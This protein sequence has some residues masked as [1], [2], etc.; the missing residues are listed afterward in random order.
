MYKQS[1]AFKGLAVLLV[2]L[3][4][5]IVMGTAGL[6][7]INIQLSHQFQI[8]LSLLAA[9]GLYAVPL[10]LFYSGCFVRYALENRDLRTSYKIIFS[11]ILIVLWPYIIW[12]IVFYLV[13][14]I[15]GGTTFSLL[16]YLKNLLVGYPFNFVPILIFFYLL[17]PLLLKAKE[18]FIVGLLV[19]FLLYQVFLILLN[20]PDLAGSL[21]E[22]LHIFA[23]PVVR[24]PLRTWALYFPLGI[25]IKFLLSNSAVVKQY[26]KILFIVLTLLILAV[27]LVS[28]LGFYSSPWIKY[29]LP[30]PFVLLSIFWQREKIPFFKFFERLGKRSYGI[31]LINLI[32]LDILVLILISVLKTIPGFPLF[33]FV[34]L[35]AITVSLPI[36]MMERFEKLVSKRIYRLIFG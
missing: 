35:F 12:S 19:F 26:L 16:G 24:E 4:H 9:F 28:V 2:V 36:F 1:T 31:Y 18:W 3:N 13:I 17:S 6:G 34:I 29:L 32:V 10:F 7:K 25:Y 27:N 33:Y 11:N 21:P 15:D 14:F 5:T 23:I 8:G 20:D 30:L 22:S